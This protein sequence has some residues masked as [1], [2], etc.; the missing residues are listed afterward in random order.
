MLVHSKDGQL[1]LLCYLLHRFLMYPAQDESASALRR[2]RIKNGLKMAQFIAGVQRFFGRII[3]LKD[4]QVGHQFQ[5]HDLLAPRF[6]NQQVARDL[7][8]KGLAALGAMNV[9]IGIGPRHAFR[10]NIIDILT[11]GYHPAQSGSQST[12]MGQNSLLEPVQPRPDRDHV[13]AH[14][15]PPVLTMLPSGASDLVLQRGER[16]SIAKASRSQK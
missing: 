6:V 16:R 14:D 9:S 13:H 3:C 11:M 1:H 5:R 10:H 12:F 2:K 7:E 15:C 4:V 8:Q